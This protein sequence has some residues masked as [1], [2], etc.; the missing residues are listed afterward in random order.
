MTLSPK[1]AIV[2][3]SG[4]SLDVDYFDIFHLPRVFPPVSCGCN[5][6]LKGTHAYYVHSDRR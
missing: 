4:R 2:W 6:A 5:A 3:L 1:Q